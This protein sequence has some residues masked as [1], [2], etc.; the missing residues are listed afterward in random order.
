MRAATIVRTAPRFRFPLA[1]AVALCAV[2]ALPAAAQEVDSFTTNQA[3]VSDPPGGSSVAT[4]GADILGQRRGLSVD[5]WSGAGPV[6]AAVSAGALTVAVAGTT[7]DSRGEAVVTWDGDSDPL[8]LSPTGLGG[9][10]LAGGGDAFR[11]TVASATAGVELTFTVYTDAGNASTYGLVLPAVASPTDID[12]PFASFLI[13]SGSGAD[14]AGVGAITLTVRGTETTLVLDRVQV[15]TSTA[16][17]TAT[18]TDNVASA[19]PGDT[20]SYTATLGSAGPGTARDLTLNNPLDPDTTLVPGSVEVSPLALDDQY[21]GATVGTGFAAG[22]PGVLLNDVD[23]DG[24]PLTVS[25]AGA[26]ATAHGGS[27]DVSADGSFTYT[28]PASFRGLDTFPYQADDGNGI[29]GP[30]V[31]TIHVDCA[32]IGVSPTTLDPAVVGTTYGPVTFLATGATAAVTWSVVGA[33]PAGLNLSAAGVLDGTPNEHGLFPL[34][35]VATDSLGCTGSQAITL[36]VNRAPEITSADNAT[37]APG[38]AGQ[39]FTVTTNG[40]PA[41]PM[42]ITRT[43]TLPAGV[44]FTDND[45]GTA[46]IAGTPE[47]GTQSGSPYLWTITASNG[48][49]PDAVQ[50]PFTFNVVCP[51]I[52][53]SGTIPALTFNTTM[54]TATFTQTGGNGTIG[55]SA[56]GLPAG[57]AVGP[58][59]GQLTGTP[60][61]TGT[62]DVVITATDAGDCTGTAN[63]SVTVAPVAVAD[64]YNGGVD[65]TQYVV[66]GGATA[67]PATPS[68]QNP[69]RIVANDLPSGGVAATAGTFATGQGG[70]VT[71]A[72]D[73]TFLYTPPARNGLPAITSDTFAYTVQSNTGGGA[74]VA[75][76]PAMVTVN[77][78]GRV[79]Y[80]LNNGLGGN[81]QSQSPLLTL[82]QA[83]GASTVNDHIFVYAGSGTTANLNNGIVLKAG[84]RLTGQGVTLVVNGNLL[85]AALANPL[86]GNTAGNGV[87]LADGNLIS[88]LTVSNPTGVGITGSGVNTL[89]VGPGVTITG[90]SGGAFALSGGNGVVA[91]GATV[92]NSSNRAI[93]IQNRT[94]GAV[95]LSGAVTATGGTGILLN[96][97][98]G[99]SSFTFSGGVTLNGASATFTATNSGT[100]A[101][102]GTN[103]IGATTPPT[104]PGL[105][106]ANTTIAASGLTFQRVSATG[107]A[108]GIVLNNT[109]SSGGLTV[110]GDGGGANN[111]SGGTIQNTTAEGVLLASTANVSLGYLN[112][113][114][115]GTDGIRITN[116]TGFTLNRSNLSDGAG[117]APADKAIDVGDF[118]TGT[119]VNGA[120]N[121]TNSVI[122]PAAGSSPHDSLAAGI[123]SGTSTWTVSGTTFRN[124]GNAG[125]NLEL[126]GTAVVTAFDVSGSTFAGAGGLVSARGVFANNLDDSV[127]TLLTVQNSTFTNNNIHIDV[128]QQNDTDPVGGSTFR[129][130]NNTTMTG[131]RSHAVNVFSAAGA[132]GGTFTGTIDGNVIGNA[133]I[134]ASGSAIGNG[135]RVNVNGGS[136]VTLR[137]SDNDVRQTPNGRGIE[138]IGRNGAGGLDV[139][140]TGNDVNPQA[141]SFPLA[142]I[143]V[144]SNCLTTCNTVRADVRDNVVPAATDVTDLLTTY[145]ELVE[146]GASTLE[147]VDTTSPVSGTCASELAAMNT[148]STGVLGACSLIAGPISTPP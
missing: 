69:T 139:T 98:G 66:T 147:L 104:G 57:L 137:L 77:L 142:A 12:L 78:A 86:I 27:A 106:V 61:V 85:V 88:G 138:I 119:A 22:A 3:A 36:T 110:T 59:N 9:A 49:E 68:V 44:T 102:T 52:T 80:V 41:T 48:I 124:T 140:V 93:S 73:G 58:V 33:L 109:G 130:L 16:A 14:F 13:R 89:T 32:T 51:A 146:S 129:I 84:Q 143:L 64:T 99:A 45:D 65:N 39:T 79:W 17:V 92:T 96:N 121:I 25:P 2:A 81:G 101:V 62:F 7:P 87:T 10:N 108:N 112:V 75:S 67:T 123:G 23:G 18:L 26:R 97:N 71:I 113:T 95:T 90:A 55:W 83:Q 54:A 70:S 1:V 29:P 125:I 145:I 74:A 53:V 4:G 132:F 118:S 46:T 8:L 117:A 148:G 131:A 40:F 31:V 28:P 114:N 47:A 50:D 5:L 103:A 37:F 72:A 6:T 24:D 82:A 141:P 126:R 133:G 144:Q 56:T 122:G 91:F 20:L 21:V 135:I 42:T 134:A 128:N 60:T 43:G 15:V 120:I 19:Q 127:M 35:F 136:D 63:L 76:A 111:G 105:N 116:I 30:G 100:L 115:P 34:T 11:L 94:G 107:G 38:L